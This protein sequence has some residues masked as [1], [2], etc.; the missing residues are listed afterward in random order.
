MRIIVVLDGAVLT[1]A[2]T[3][4]LSSY[5]ALLETALGLDLQH[6]ALSTAKH[7]LPSFGSCKWSV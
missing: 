4:L 3:P 2:L 1:L 5:Q 6:E 7:V